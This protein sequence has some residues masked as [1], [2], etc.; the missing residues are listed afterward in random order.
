MP[1]IFAYGS[2]MWE[3]DFDIEE[4]VKGVLAGYHREFN[5][6]STRGWGTREAPAP[7]LGLEE[8]GQCVGL[9]FRIADGTADE[10]RATIDD[11][12]EPSYSR[13]TENIRLAD[14]RT[15]TASVWINERNFTYIGDKPLEERARMAVTA[16]GQNG[17]AVDYVLGTRRTLHERGEVDPVSRNLPRTSLSSPSELSPSTHRRSVRGQ[18]VPG[19]TPRERAPR[20]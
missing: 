4:Q 3:Y 7:V 17:A 16:A 1:W 9:T 20:I 8:G 18:Q 12:E 11:R 13:R 5:K 2:L 15:V 6:Q 19:G 14:G 10:I